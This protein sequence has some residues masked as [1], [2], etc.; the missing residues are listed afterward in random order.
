MTYLSCSVN[1]VAAYASGA[2]ASPEAQLIAK[3]GVSH[4]VY[5]LGITIFT[6][7]FGIAPMILAPFSEINGR[8]PVF[9]AT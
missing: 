9:I 3:W 1:A 4:V 8:R 2:Y 5:N 7:G 6:I